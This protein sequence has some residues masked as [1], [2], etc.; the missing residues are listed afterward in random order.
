MLEAPEDLAKSE[1]PPLAVRLSLSPP[2]NPRQ[3]TRLTVQPGGGEGPCPTTVPKEGLAQRYHDAQKD[4]VCLLLET[5]RGGRNFRGARSPD[6][7]SIT[8]P[9]ARR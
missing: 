8:Q 6:A 9:V 2:L 1:Q 4:P 3:S 5:P 7:L